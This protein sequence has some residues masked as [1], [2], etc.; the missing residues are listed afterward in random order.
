LKSK[1]PAEMGR[2]APPTGL[3]QVGEYF[4]VS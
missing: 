1:F 2:D 4:G 3:A